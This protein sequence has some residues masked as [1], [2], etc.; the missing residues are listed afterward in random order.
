V[1]SRLA[2]LLAA[3]VQGRTAAP[4]HLRPLQVG[5]LDGA[6]SMPIGDQ[7]QRRVALAEINKL[8]AAAKHGRYAALALNWAEYERS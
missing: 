1:N 4:F 2:V 8:I 3:D 5:D 6:Q 7:D